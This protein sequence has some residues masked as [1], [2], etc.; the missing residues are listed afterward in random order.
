M[1]FKH[2]LKIR[3]KLQEKSAKSIDFTLNVQGPDP[4]G[5]REGLRRAR[6]DHVPV[7]EAEEL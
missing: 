5:R 1:L 6:Q 2:R 4:A 7:Q 3:K